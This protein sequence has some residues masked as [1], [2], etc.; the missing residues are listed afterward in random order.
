VGQ[1]PAPG[2][3]SSPWVVPDPVAPDEPYDERR[4]RLGLAGQA[5]APGSGVECESEQPAPCEDGHVEGV[6]FRDVEVA[7]SPRRSRWRGRRA[8]TR[9]GPSGA[10]SPSRHPQRNAAVARR[11]RHAVLA[12][13]ER[14]GG[15][16]QVFLVR[17]GDGGRS[18]S[19]RVRPTGR[20]AGATDEWWPAVALARDGAV[21]VAW[22]DRSSGRERVYFSRSPGFG[23]GFAPPSPLDAAAPADAAQWKPALAQGPGGVVHAVFVDERHSHP[24]G[25]PQAGIFYTRLADGGPEP[26]RRLDGGEPV[27]L[28]ANLDNA[29]APGVDA[30]GG[31]VL[32]SW[33]DFLHYDW[34]VFARAS[35]DGGDSFGAT[36]QV[37]GEA[38]EGFGDSP[39]AV[40]GATRPFVAFTDFGPG[41]DSQ[42]RP[43]PMY[44][45]YVAEPGGGG[46]HQA[47]PHGRRHASAFAGG[48]CAAGGD[49]V[50]VAFQDA[51]NGQNDIRVARMSGGERRGRAH[52]VDDAGRSGGNAWRP[53]LACSRGGVLAAWEDE[54]DGPP[55]VYTAQARSRRLR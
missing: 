36:D 34:D 47:D 32:V 46:P 30:R 53:R 6:F 17:S 37:N 21:T 8:R 11:G 35:S 31:R 49:D 33:T 44:D 22:V 41:E 52:R 42:R 38:G 16:D 15:R 4:R 7:R 2:L 1:P 50:L 45:V 10:A 54:R 19:R 55:Q 13:E 20:P 26:A 51:R 23:A 12:F 3:Q 43:H 18:W 9:F 27:P 40:L 24:N 39:Q 48:A 14:R 29:W 28:A 5:L 25:T